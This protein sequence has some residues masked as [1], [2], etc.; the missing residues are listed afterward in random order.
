MLSSCL[1]VLSLNTFGA[2]DNVVYIEQMCA[3]ND[4]IFLSETW[5]KEEQKYILS[6]ISSDHKV[7][8]KSDMIISP[9]FCRHYG[10]RAWFVR[11]SIE[12]VHSD[13]INEHVSVIVLKKDNILFTLMGV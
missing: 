4:V 13:F 2:D 11:K 5:L 1:S 12:V 8:F 6:G 7:L 3:E 9:R 10:G